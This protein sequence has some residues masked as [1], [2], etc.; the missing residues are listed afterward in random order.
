MRNCFLL[1]AFCFCAGLSA[2]E[3]LTWNTFER[4]AFEEVYDK[5]SASWLQ[6]PVWTNEFKVW[7]GKQVKV[8]GYVIVLD[9]V[10]KIY[11]LSAFPFSSCFFCGAA[12]PESVLELD[13]DAKTSQTFITDDVVTFVG[14]LRLN[15]D[16]LLFPLTL[17]K[18]TVK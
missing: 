17:Q 15:Q 18:A 9:P 14:I 6:A 10:E 11:A 3:R 8:T 5:E 7:D 4:L 13:L 1:I 2:Q 12:G 16:P